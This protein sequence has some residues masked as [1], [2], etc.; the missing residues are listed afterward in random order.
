MKNNTVWYIPDMYWPET[1][2]GTDYVSHESICVLNTEEENAQ[3]SLTLYYEDQ[4]PIGPVM[5][6][7]LGKRTHHIRMDRILLTEERHIP[8]GVPYAAVLTSSVPVVVQYTRV[9]TTQPELALMSA[10]AFPG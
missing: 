3:I 7:C 9:D 2:N 8:R 6:Q 5:C 1:S 4:E 10:M